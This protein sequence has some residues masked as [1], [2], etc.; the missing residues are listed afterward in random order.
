MSFS[1]SQLD[2]YLDEIKTGCRSLGIE[3]NG[4]KLAA[5]IDYLTLFEKWNRAYNL[6]AI[7]KSDDMPGKHILDSLSVL[8]HLQGDTFVDVGSG[9]GLPGIP[10]A[11]SLPDKHFTL[12]DANGKKTRFLFQVKQALKLDNVS[13]ENRRVEEF[14]PE[15]PFDGLICRAY[16]S[17]NGI[18]DTAGHLHAKEGKI[19]AMKGLIPTDELSELQKHYIVEAI[20]K[21]DVPGVT[22]ERNLIVLA[23]RKKLE[24]L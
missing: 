22:G 21:L 18:I 8:P 10:L 7:R 9:G 23:M 4:D 15:T 16:S 5:Y 17:I 11:I 14:R 13:V 6:S 3:T 20:K 1:P 12:L 2:R 24:N 19:F